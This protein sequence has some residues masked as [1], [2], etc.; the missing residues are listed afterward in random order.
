[1]D[2]KIKIKLLEIIKTEEDE[3]FQRAFK[4]NEALMRQ[5]KKENQSLQR[6][7]SKLKQ[8]SADK[9]SEDRLT[10]LPPQ[11]PIKKA[12]MRMNFNVL[13]HVKKVNDQKHINQ[14]K[15]AQCVKVKQEYQ[16]VQN[17]TNVHEQE[18]KKRKEKIKTLEARLEVVKLK[19]MGAQKTARQCQI[20]KNKMEKIN[21]TLKCELNNLERLN[22][23]RDLNELDKVEQL[24]RKTLDERPEIIIRAKAKLPFLDDNEGSSQDAED[25]EVSPE[26]EWIHRSIQ[27]IIGD[28]DEDVQ[29][30]LRPFNTL[31]KATQRILQE[32]E[33][34][35]AVL[36]ERHRDLHM[37]QNQKA[38]MK[39]KPDKELSGWVEKFH[40]LHQKH[41]ASRARRNQRLRSLSEIN[42][43]ITLLLSRLD[44]IVP[45]KDPASNVSPYSEEFVLTQL[46]ELEQKLKW[47]QKRCQDL[48][49]VD[50]QGGK[51][52]SE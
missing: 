36:K 29:W 24:L 15:Q 26:L 16:R 47:L 23:T 21:L 33:A 12:A 42:I 48:S 43:A 41:D 52:Q 4:K 35:E 51:G 40:E 37:F 34:K 1:M 46:T 39:S 20:A 18:Q 8:F 14:I 50:K 38:N 17:Q 5:L 28:R 7:M 9:G 11:V 3:E 32:K 27:S 10:C 25:E 31:N 19:G 49:T 44:H 6:E 30:M 22:C 13:P 2:V 45:A